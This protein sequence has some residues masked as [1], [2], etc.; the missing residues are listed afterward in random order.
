MS[1]LDSYPFIYKD[2]ETYIACKYDWSDVLEKIDYILTNYNELQPYLTEN[3]K[4][5]YTQQYSNESLVKYF[6]NQLSTVQ[7]I[8]HENN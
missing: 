3:I 8:G 7:G 6:Y 5:E 1:H 2:K 4:N